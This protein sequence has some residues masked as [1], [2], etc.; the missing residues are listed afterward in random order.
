MNPFKEEWQK[1][2]NEID[3]EDGSCALVDD[4]VLL[5]AENRL[6]KM[7]SMLERAALHVDSIELSDEIRGFLD[8][9]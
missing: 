6:T 4:D 1:H 5:W 3:P 2:I 7:Q 8:E 9:E